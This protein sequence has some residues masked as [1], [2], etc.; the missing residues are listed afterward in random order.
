[1]QWS[2]LQPRES[3]IAAMQRK[4]HRNSAALHKE[5]PSRSRDGQQTGHSVGFFCRS[6]W[7][8]YEKMTILFVMVK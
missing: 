3:T 5:T 6:S 1:M 7:H 4:V 2:T 8:T